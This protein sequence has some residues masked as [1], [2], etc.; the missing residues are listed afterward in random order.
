MGAVLDNDESGTVGIVKP[1]FYTFAE[2]PHEMNL[3]CGAK[4]GPITLAYETYGEL[5]AEKSNA[6]LVFHAF[7]GDAHVAG[8]SEESDTKYGWW[9]SMV[10][11]GKGMDTN[12]YFVIC[13]NVLGGCKGSTGPS[14][15]NPAT[16]RPYGMSFPSI[17]I[18]DMVRSQK[19]LIDHLGIKKL[20][21]VVGGSMGGML[22]LQWTLNYPESVRLSIPIA[23]TCR[24]S[25]QNIAFNEVGRRAIMSDPNWNN[26][27]YYDSKSPDNGLA[28]ARMIGHITYLSERNLQRKFGR[29][30][31]DKDHFAFD[32]DSPEFE[33]ESYLAYKG[34]TFTQRFD[35]NSYLYITRALDYFDLGE[36]HR[37]LAERFSSIKNVSF[38]I[39]SYS[40]DWLYP[41]YQSEEIVKAL[42]INNIDVT[43][44][45]IDSTYGHDGF[46]LEVDK[47]KQIFKHFLARA[48][49]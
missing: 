49:H 4:L 20:L 5:N 15:I 6:I 35:A 29:K 41:P 17:T 1:Q 34:S 46:L 39:I 22:C 25:A 10:G 38:L 9:D 42:Q 7:S 16:G 21:A 44:C 48:H 30:L 36:G 19:A 33:V 18:G 32:F 2:S 37:S 8:K 14:S 28:I 45:K 40:S 13:I 24:H 11:P 26:G 43:Y 31:Q 47:M 3:D 27:D 12:K 23:S